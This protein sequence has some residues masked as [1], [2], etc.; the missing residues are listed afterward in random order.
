MHQTT[1]GATI[2][3]A[4]KVTRRRFW[5]VGHGPDVA[6]FATPERALGYIADVAWQ[7]DRMTLVSRMLD[8]APNGRGILA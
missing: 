5:I 7:G 8:L 4:E 6:A 2:A 3:P 1:T